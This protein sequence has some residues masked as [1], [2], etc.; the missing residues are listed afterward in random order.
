MVK[1]GF[2]SDC[3]RIL[4]PG[5]LVRFVTDDLPYAK[6]VKKNAMEIPELVDAE[7]QLPAY[8]PSGFELTFTGLQ[9]PIHRLAW[10]KVGVIRG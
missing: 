2:L 8:P 3:V 9:K 5:G 1:A 6:D 7:P 4:K 10:R